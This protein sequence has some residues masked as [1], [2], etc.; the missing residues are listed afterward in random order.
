MEN[1]FKKG[2]ILGGLLAVGAAIGLAMT[3]EGKELTEEMQKDLKALAKHLKKNLADIE[4]VTKEKFDD[5]ATTT[6][7]EY[8]AKKELAEDTKKAFVKALQAT[9]HDMEAEYNDLKK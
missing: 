1:K 6:V 4:D 9:W 3:H 7:E 5:I 2:L 8:V